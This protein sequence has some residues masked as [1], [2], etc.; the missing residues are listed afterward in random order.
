M[1]HKFQ[2]Y[3]KKG[4][5]RR[6]SPDKERAKSLMGESE[7]KLRSLK[8]K[9]EKLGVYDENANDYV[10]YCYD[11]L[12]LMVRALMYSRGYNS[13]G[14]GAHEAEINFLGEIGFSR[15]DIEFLDKLRYYRNGILYYGTSFDAEYALK[16]IKFTKLNHTR[17]RKLL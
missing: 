3:L 8:E 6:M 11:T 7:R 10:E 17:L 13:S 9:V 4:I 16:V 2:E 5:V 1:K 14:Y 15:Q 12:M